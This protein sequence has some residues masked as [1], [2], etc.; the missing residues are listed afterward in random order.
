VRV[1]LAA[2]GR[3]RSDRLYR[4]V[5]DILVELDPDPPDSLRRLAR[6]G[7]VPLFISTTFDSLLARA[8]DRERFGGQQ[9]TRELW[10]SPNQC[11]AEQQTNARPPVADEAVGFEI[12]GQAS[13]TP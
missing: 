9:G 1:Y 8:I 5:N 11:T 2:K 6:I 3:D 13:S 12:F 4:V 10:F 7:D